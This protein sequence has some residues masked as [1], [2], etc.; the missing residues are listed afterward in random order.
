MGSSL[1]KKGHESGATSLGGEAREGSVT[2]LGT[3]HD[4]HNLEALG[5]KAELRRNRS[6]FTLLF[7]S[8]AIA[9][10]S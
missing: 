10:V 8:L 1:E 7:Q 6:M 9:A 4:V 2:Q 3:V 5:Y